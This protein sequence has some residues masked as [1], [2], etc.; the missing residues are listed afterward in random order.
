[1]AQATPPRARAVSSATPAIV[2]EKA[3]TRQGLG[4]DPRLFVGR[5]RARSHDCAR[6]KISRWCQ[7]LEFDV[8]RVGTATITPGQIFCYLPPPD[9]VGKPAPQN[10]PDAVG[11]LRSERLCEE[12]PTFPP[13]RSFKQSP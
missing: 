8:A 5:H 1:V 2:T 11:A 3:E 4:G 13:C 10:A 12:A 6:R 9:D 7:P